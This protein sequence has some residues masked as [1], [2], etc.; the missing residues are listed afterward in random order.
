MRYNRIGEDLGIPESA[1]E[2]NLMFTTDKI[3][4]TMEVAMRADDAEEWFGAAPPDLSTG[5]RRNPRDV[6]IMF[7]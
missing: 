6:G 1:I 4:D 7:L 3:Q 5:K 2:T